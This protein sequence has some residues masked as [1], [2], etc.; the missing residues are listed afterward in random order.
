MDEALADRPRRGRGAVGNPVGRFEA[1]DRVAT[2][3]GWG[4]AAA[5]PA[6]LRTTL[7]VDSA[8]G[9]ITRNQ[10]PDVPFDRSINPYKGCE[11]GCIYCFAR[12]THAW[13]GLSPGLDFETRLYWK[14]DAPDLLARELRNP[15]YRAATIALGANTDP[16]QPVER[17]RKLT[18][19]ILEVLAAFDHPVGIVTKSDL[20]LRDLDILEPMAAKNLVRVAVS[21]TTLDRGLSRR[22]EPRAPVQARRL[23]AIGGLA[24][25]GIPATVLNAPIIP[26]LNDHEI[27]AILDS[28]ARAG[29]TAAGYVLLRLPHEVKDLFAD[30]LAA[31]YP[32]RARRVMSLVR[33]TRGG[34]LYRSEWGRRQT[35]G[36]AYAEQIA[37]RFDLA[38]K[39]LGLHHGHPPLDESRF[40]RP[41]APGDQLALL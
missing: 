36:G 7:S 34:K 4:A 37:D 19:R 24:R 1:V 21:V 10:S 29:A 33:Q 41:P 5:E 28:A 18:R 15:K 30:W 6:P 40:R 17:E 8:R 22:L 20:V 31:H 3:D 9:I 32:D 25:A 11:H 16:Y 27:E 26:A 39:R 23:A 2:D 38:C 14:P 12:P 13:L 35:G